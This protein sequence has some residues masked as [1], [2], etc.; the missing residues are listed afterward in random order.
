MRGCDV[1]HP[2]TLPTF[3]AQPPNGAIEFTQSDIS[4]GQYNGFQS[5][6]DIRNGD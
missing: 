2:L 4:T 6:L 1:E 5:I 3:F